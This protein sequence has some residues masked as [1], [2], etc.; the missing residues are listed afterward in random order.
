VL[1]KGITVQGVDLRQLFATDPELPGRAMRE[2][3]SMLAAR[4]LTPHVHATYA[5]DDVVEALRAVTERQVIG[6]VVITP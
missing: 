1:L 6:K 2:L 5:L 3:L 4:R